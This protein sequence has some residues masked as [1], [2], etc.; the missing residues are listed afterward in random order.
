MPT[1]YIISF[2]SHTTLNLRTT[3][4]YVNDP[5]F[6]AIN[7]IIVSITISIHKLIT[8][9]W[10]LY[11][12]LGDLDS[13][14]AFSYLTVYQFSR[15][16]VSSFLQPNGLQHARLPYPS[17]APRVYST[18]VHQVRDAIQPSH[19]LL[20]SSPLAFNLSQHQG[21]FQ[22][23]NSSHQVAKVFEHQHQ[24]YLTVYDLK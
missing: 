19:P 10:E 22:W 1:L 3:C 2:N 17:P 20:S 13:S 12:E 8:E 21:L 11:W 23:V 24:S 18:H 5:E 15:S 7:I 9:S 4:H 14:L 6:L 16:I